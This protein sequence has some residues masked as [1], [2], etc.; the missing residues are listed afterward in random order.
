MDIK[1]FF[2]LSAGKWFVQRTSYQLCE[3][4][5]ENSKSEIINEILGSD[6]SAVIQLC[7]QHRVDINSI[8]GGLKSSWDT[9]VDWGKKKQTGWSILIPVGNAENSDQGK[10]LRS[11]SGKANLSGSLSYV[12]GEDEALTITYSSDSLHMEERLWFA[13]PNLRLR[14]S[15]AKNGGGY[16]QTTFYSE[17]RRVPPQEKQE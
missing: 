9:G 2:E 1:E 14:T 4:K 15:L 8:W 5:A 10:I 6:D 12:M 17:I 16:T 13:S 11:V 3:E 7:Q